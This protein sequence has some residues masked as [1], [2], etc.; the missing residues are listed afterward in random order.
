MTSSFTYPESTPAALLREVR[1]VAE[2]I[3]YYNPENG[4]TIARLAPESPGDEAALLHGDERLLTVVGTLVDLTPGEAIV[5]SGWWRN[6]PKYGWQFVVVDYRTTLPAT[7]QGMRRYLGSGLVKGIGPVYAARIIEVFGEETF[8]VIDK[9]PERLNEVAGI[10]KVRAGRIAATW[11]EQRQIRD[12]MTALHSYGVST[13]LAVRIYKKF[14]EASARIVTDEPYRL[15]REVWGIGF[16]TA[17]KIAACVGI[18][19]DAPARLQ[20]G[21]LH[22]VGLA[23]EVGHT[24]LAEEPLVEQSEEL[25]Q[26]NRELIHA[27]VEILVESGELVLALA[28]G[29]T[30]R[31]FA[32]APFARAESGLA[33][34]LHA[35]TGARERSRAVQTFGAVDWSVVFGW[36]A[37]RHQIALS[38]EQDS[39]I[40]M[41]L[42]E[43]T[44]ILTGGPGT[45]KTHTL[46]G[47]LTVARVKGLRCL[48]AAPTGRAA[49]RMEEATGVPA[50]TL[51]RVL[52]IR[53]GCG[54]AF[55]PD[56]PLLAD[57][58]VVDETSMLDV[59]LANQLVKALAPGTHLLLV[60]DPD[61]LP[62]VGAGDVLADLLR[63]EQ[64]PVTRLTRIFRQGA[65]SGIA[66]NAERIKLGQTPRFGGEVVDCFFVEAETPAE[67]ADVVVEL[68]AERLPRRYGFSRG[69]IQVLV[70][71]HRGV[72]GVAAL[73]TRLQERLNPPQAGLAEARSG[74]R[75]F[76][77]G[78]RVLQLRNDYDLKVFNGDLGMVG[79]IDPVEQELRLSLDD[80]REVPYPFAGLFALTH[81][82]AISVHKCI[83]G[84]QRV[85]TAN[86][87]LI[88][89]EQVQIG[90]LVYTSDHSVH[91]VLSVIETGER[92]VIRIRTR[93]GYQLDV[94]PEHPILVADDGPPRFVAISDIQPGQFACLSRRVVEGDN[95][96]LLPRAEFR[97]EERSLYL[98]TVLDE[99]FAWWLGVVIGDGSYRDRRDGTVDLTSLDAEVLAKY[100]TVLEGYGL[101]VGVYRH[102]A[103]RATRLYVISQRFRG[104][105]LQLGLDYTTATQKSV[106]ALIFRARPEVRAAFVRGLF[107]TNGSAGKGITRSCRLVTSSHQLATGVQELLLSLG[108]VSYLS[109]VTPRAWCIGVS[110]TSLTQFAKW[111]GFSVVG[112]QRRLEAA[113]S[114]RHSPGAHTTNVD[115]V[116]FGQ[117]VVREVADYL[118]TLW[119]ST[120][121]RRGQAMYGGWL[122]N[123]RTARARMVAA[124]RSV[125]SGQ[126]LSYARL[127]DLRTGL[128]DAEA[129]IP[130]LVRE[131]EVSDFFYDRVIAVELTGERT[132][133]YDLEV[134]GVHA[135]V[136]NGF[137]CHNSQGA[138]FPAVVLPLLTTHAPMLGRTLLYTAFTRARQLVVLVGQRKAL[139]LAVRD[140]RRTDRTTALADL[141][142]GTLQFRWP[143]RRAEAPA[144]EEDEQ[145]WEGM[146]AAADE[147]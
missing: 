120:K 89:I 92:P 102:P 97:S 41:A 46:R 96:V 67:A 82:Y 93:M 146:L 3:T 108:I 131:T 77:P 31:R 88:P 64:F 1:G 103:R 49:K 113:L 91:S 128:E 85:R 44:S 42:T 35:L 121:G 9:T 14:G 118:H 110:G 127:R 53:P 28:P 79:A 69:D 104:W 141:L 51:H 6:D 126:G 106:P 135:F 86:R 99:D 23:A 73:N 34:R 68:V 10:G 52:E 5:A 16:K 109:Q 11:L 139:Y 37:Q 25:L 140:W 26:A 61:Q 8:E 59:L 65:G 47:L 90:D 30:E 112:K 134:E 15:A 39:A 101:R 7:L 20:A 145:V 136:S 56:Q 95:R 144:V 57:L 74:G 137:V 72:V 22:A 13:S 105:L 125:R 116:P 54:A 12:V 19:P 130:V 18:A 83:A 81:A 71:M 129:P 84:Y 40:R 66:R 138:E 147:R 132:V 24:L 115:S 50:G 29:S 48:L 63:S 21:V 33:T 60:G 80:G 94:S 62:S 117:L 58:V 70:P 142:L 43:P 143:S 45:G 98:P 55:G 124:Y 87:G 36:L 38:A 27:A 100:R 4:Y 75:V 76:R 32:L 78:D 107:D 111:I 122:T 2:R 119:G 17:D 123:R 114:G 133:M